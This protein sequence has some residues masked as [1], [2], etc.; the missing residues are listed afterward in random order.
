MN[1]H[2]TCLSPAVETG[3][4][5]VVRSN[6]MSCLDNLVS[7]GSL[8]SKHGTGAPLCSMSDKI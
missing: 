7:E 6:E 1:I 8:G 5:K 3:S 4:A 2:S